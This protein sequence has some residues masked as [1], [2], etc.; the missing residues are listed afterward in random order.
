LH[1]WIPSG[2]WVEYPVSY[3]S[4]FKLFSCLQVQVKCLYKSAVCWLTL[5]GTLPSPLRY[6]KY[7]LFLFLFCFVFL[8][9]VYFTGRNY[10]PW[11]LHSEIRI[12]GWYKY[13]SMASFEAG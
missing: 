5:G 13:F 12:N 6:E 1:R 7:G 2:S 11:Y 8:L 10:Y 4:T 9:L 3:P